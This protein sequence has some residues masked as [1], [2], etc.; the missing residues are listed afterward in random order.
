[1]GQQELARGGV[2]EVGAAH[3]LAYLLGSII[4]RHGEL[5]GWCAVVAADGEVVYLLFATA[6]Q[7]VLESHARAL[8]PYPEG[9]RSSGRPH[10][11]R[12]RLR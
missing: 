10:A 2:D 11:R 4:N 7:T 1:M 6:E 5:I 9:G 3:H 8:R 12:A